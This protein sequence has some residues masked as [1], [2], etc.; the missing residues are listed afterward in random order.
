MRRG[1]V[2][3][4]VLP[5]FPLEDRSFLASEKRSNRVFYVPASMYHTVE[6]KRGS[7]RL[8]QEVPTDGKALETEPERRCVRVCLPSEIL[9]SSPTYREL[10]RGAGPDTGY[11]SW[12]GC[13]LSVCLPQRLLW[14]PETVHRTIFAL[15]VL[16][17]VAEICEVLLLFCFLINQSG[18]RTYCLCVLL[19]VSESAG[20]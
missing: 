14:V 20:A 18:K 7:C 17:P 8:N 3:E 10:Q 4:V 15:C 16:C 2:G 5:F 12:A 19:R 13:R 6:R 11:I 9:R 1:G